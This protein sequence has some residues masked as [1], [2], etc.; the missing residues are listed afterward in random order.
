MSGDYGAGQVDD[1]AAEVALSRHLHVVAKGLA[2]A[3]VEG[4]AEGAN[5]IACVVQVVFAL[6]LVTCCVEHIRER[7]AEHRAAAVADMK[8]T[9]RVRADELHLHSPAAADSNVAVGAGGVQ[10]GGNQLEEP[11]VLNSEVNEP[12]CSDADRCNLVYRLQAAYDDMRELERTRP[13][14]A[15]QF[16]RDSGREV[17]VCGVLRA[18][19]DHFRQRGERDVTALLSA[20]NSVSQALRQLQSKHR[21]LTPLYVVAPELRHPFSHSSVAGCAV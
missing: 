2:I 3:G 13:H 20:V 4:F 21:V 17:T 6:D 7:A 11:V 10:Y 8:R 9:G 18:F 16:Q 12:R 19:D 1:V 14:G 15:G 5:L